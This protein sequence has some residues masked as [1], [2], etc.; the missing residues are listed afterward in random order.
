[1]LGT[2]RKREGRHSP[3]RRD[4]APTHPVVLGS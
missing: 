1:L 3:A 4:L 2:T